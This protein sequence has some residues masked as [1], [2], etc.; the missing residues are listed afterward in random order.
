M[1]FIR[2]LVQG[3][4]D[5]LLFV[6]AISTMASALYTLSLKYI[7]DLIRNPTEWR[8]SLL[9]IVSMIVGSSIVSVISGRFLTSIYENRIAKLR[10]DL[11]NQI[12]NA[13]FERVEKN[14]PLIVPVLQND[15]NTMTTFTRS[16]AEMIMASLKVVM[17]LGYLF[18]ISWVFGTYIFAVFMVIFL[19]NLTLLKPIYTNEKSIKLL[20]NLI[21]NRL[22]GMVEGI[23]ELTLSTVH[24]KSYVDQNIKK[25]SMKY[26]ETVTQAQTYKQFLTKF[27][28]TLALLAILAFSIL[29]LGQERV[30]LSDFIEAFTLVVFLLPSL[31][32]VIGFTR[33]IKSF[34][35][36]LEQIEQLGLEFRDV[37]VLKQVE[38]PIRE[39][40]HKA[41]IELRNASYTYDSSYTVG[42]INLKIQSGEI[43]IIKGG[44]GSGK[45]TLAKLLTGLY[46]TKEGE[47]L[48]QGV[49]VTKDNLTGFRNIFSAVFTDSHVFR[50]LQYLQDRVAPDDVSKWMDRLEISEKVSLQDLQVSSTDLSFGQR[51]RLNLLRALLEDKP[52]YLFDEWA[53]NQDPHF[54]SV[55][56]QQILPEMKAMGKTIIVISHDDKYYGV[57]DR[58]VTLSGGSISKIEDKSEFNI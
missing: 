5:K 50:N 45:T 7:N 27:S 35:V 37:E 2:F 39:G 25:G 56:Y 19:L 17:I 26:A 49:C 42:P 41:L 29:F 24:H 46:Q 16:I 33:Q 54:K 30:V 28:E 11:S 48:V 14:A 43:V 44:N 3:I 58:I 40:D 23:K 18:Y 31:I 9:L 51:G 15:I 12:I 32:T 34:Q 55:F 47:L 53:A 57:A 13:D 36:S 20:R 8:D 1:K 52:V 4:W 21:H 10:V 22:H 6:I 38:M